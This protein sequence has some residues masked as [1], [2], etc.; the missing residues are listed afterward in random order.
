MFEKNEI[1]NWDENDWKKKAFVNFTEDLTGKNPK[2]PCIFGTSG[3]QKN[4]LRFDFFQRIDIES[5]KLLGQSLIEYLKIAKKLGSYTSFVAFFNIETN[6]DVEEYEK[7]FWQVLNMLHRIDE[8]PWPEDISKDTNNPQWEFSFGGEPIFVVCNTPAHKL[9]KSR[10]ASTFMITFQPRW[11]F[12]EI[13]LLTPKGEKSKKV[14]RELLKKYDDISEYPYLGSY[15]D[16]ENKEWLQYFISETNEVS[17][18]EK[19]PFYQMLNQNSME[20]VKYVSG[21]NISLEQAVFELLPETGSVE[22][23]RDTP[24]REHKTHTHPTN[25]TLLIIEGEITF[26]AENQKISC[27]SGDRILLPAN[28]KHSSIAGP[29]GCLYIIALEF[30]NPEIEKTKE[31]VGAAL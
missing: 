10:S 4:E 9:R 24:L 21:K 30:V 28:T 1:L 19:C 18:I 7:D 23:Q 20:Q 11:V 8:S 22:V 3:Y 29:N 6:K 13:G 5:I 2:F 14:V 26:Y 12:D 27:K 15:G 25:E 17:N 31:K 16:P